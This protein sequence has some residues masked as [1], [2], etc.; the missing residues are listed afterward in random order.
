MAFRRKEFSFTNSAGISASSQYFP[1][2]EA[3]SKFTTLDRREN[4]PFKNFKV[5]NKSG[6]SLTFY[7]DPVGSDSTL[8]FTVPNG[9]T[10]QSQD[11][12]DF[13]FHNFCI[14]NNGLID[15]NAGEL[16]IIVRNY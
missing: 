3:T 8:K 6:V 16:N 1:L 10:L 11:D 13:T 15:I 12:E 14:I 9:Q 4:M 7:L 2:S 5:E